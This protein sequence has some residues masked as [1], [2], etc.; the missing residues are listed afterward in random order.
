MFNFP[1]FLKHCK[2]KRKIY[3]HFNKFTFLIISIN[4]ISICRESVRLNDEVG[5][6]V[7]GE[8]RQVA[9]QME[10]DKVRVFIEEVDKITSLV[11]GL[12]SR[13]VRAN[14]NPRPDTQKSQVRAKLK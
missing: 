2:K 11:I 4:Q 14:L 7:L 8:L 13:L 9:Q 10:V 5:K 3:F 6:D 12:T 1:K